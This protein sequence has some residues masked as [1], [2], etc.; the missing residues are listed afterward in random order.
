MSLIGGNAVCA[1]GGPLATKRA[2]PGD[3]SGD[4][5]LPGVDL[6]KT[7]VAVTTPREIKQKH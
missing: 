7:K 6:R 1:S 2:G 3:G 5:V 4:L